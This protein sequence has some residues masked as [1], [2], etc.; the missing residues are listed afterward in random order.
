MRI[1]RISS[2]GMVGGRSISLSA[3]GAFLTSLW[4]RSNQ[5][6]WSFGANPWNVLLRIP[7]EIKNSSKLE[8]IPDTWKNDEGKRDLSPCLPQSQTNKKRHNIFLMSFQKY[9]KKISTFIQS[10]C[11]C[12]YLS[13][14]YRNLFFVFLWMRKQILAEIILL[15][16][17]QRNLN[18]CLAWPKVLVHTWNTAD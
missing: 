11:C 8:I 12:N 14:C 5:H 17:C 10:R 2:L 7:A 18:T 6:S 9:F 13:C 4:L 1:N 3:L 15:S 16:N